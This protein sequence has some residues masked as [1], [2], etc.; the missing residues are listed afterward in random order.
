MDLNLWFYLNKI[1]LVIQLKQIC[2]EYPFVCTVL[3]FIISLYTAFIARNRRNTAK[4][5]LYFASCSLTI[6]FISVLH[7][8]W[9]SYSKFEILGM[10]SERIPPKSIHFIGDSHTAHGTL[11]MGFL[12]KLRSV[13]PNTKITQESYSGYTISEIFETIN[14]TK[15]SRKNSC[16]TVIFAGTNDSVQ[17]IPSAKSVNGMK[18]ILN[19]ESKRSSELFVIIPHSVNIP[20]FKKNCSMLTHAL[21]SL[22]SS[23][24]FKI[25]DWYKNSCG[26]EVRSNDKIHLNATGH[27]ALAKLFVQALPQL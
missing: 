27:T 7:L 26:K 22:S 11:P 23:H 25:I 2:T 24:N 8:R 14:K 6:T 16:I 4:F 19:M 17:N 5:I 10:T 21:R 9:D 3:I 18:K 1:S 20:K 12:S 15:S 13:L